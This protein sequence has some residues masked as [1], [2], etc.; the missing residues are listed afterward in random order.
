MSKSPSIEKFTAMIAMELV[1][2][3]GSLKLV[4]NVVVRGLLPK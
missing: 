3:E 4:Q 1:L 2:K